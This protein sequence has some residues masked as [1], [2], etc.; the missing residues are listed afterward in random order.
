MLV[1]ASPPSTPALSTVHSTSWAL[2]NCLWR[3]SILALVISMGLPV[4][5]SFYLIS[6]FVEDRTH[7]LNTSYVYL[8][9]TDHCPFQQLRWVPT[10]LNKA[11][12]S[13]LLQTDEEIHY[14]P[15]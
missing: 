3:L 4:P 7:S 2:S 15:M 1:F 8:L 5:D 9:V 12:S 14:F 13:L 10:E 6:T 11:E